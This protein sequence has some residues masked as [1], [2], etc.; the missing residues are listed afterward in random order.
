VGEAGGG[1]SG[2]ANHIRTRKGTGGNSITPKKRINWGIDKES[3]LAVAEDPL[4][5][6][7]EMD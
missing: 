5:G 6:V 4:R 1:I 3:R 7:V 2:D